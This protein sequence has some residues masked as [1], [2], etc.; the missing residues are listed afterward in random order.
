MRT[1]SKCSIHR[2]VLS[3]Q[4][5]F[6]DWKPDVI[7]HAAAE[8]L[9]LD[10]PS[11]TSIPTHAVWDMVERCRAKEAEDRP[12]LTKILE[13]LTHASKDPPA[14]WPSLLPLSTLISSSS[15]GSA[16]WPQS[17]SQATPLSLP[18]VLWRSQIASDLAQ[19]PQ[20]S[21]TVQLLVHND[22]PML[23]WR[24]MGDG[25]KKQEPGLKKRNTE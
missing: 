10:R 2:Q 23:R 8:G 19:P 16:P 11:W 7:R 6:Y 13:C 18:P 9:K 12:A 21:V 3:G 17:S 15:G 25:I 24:V 5:P 4:R 22:G 20:K 14:E 1:K